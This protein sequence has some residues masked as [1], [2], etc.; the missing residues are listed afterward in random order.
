MIN[1]VTVSYI[2]MSLEIVMDLTRF[3]YKAR[4]ICGMEEAYHKCTVL[5][6]EKVPPVQRHGKRMLGE[7]MGESKGREGSTK[8]GSPTAR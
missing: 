1:I 4:R 8:F 3:S 2:D 7:F 6:F 5:Q